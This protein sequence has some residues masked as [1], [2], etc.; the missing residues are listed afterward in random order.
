MY[1]LKAF[2]E[3]T[4]R[5]THPHAGDIQW[6]SRRAR[7]AWEAAAFYA[8]T[9]DGTRFSAGAFSDLHLSRLS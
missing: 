6:R 9:P 4:N 2:N 3:C 8:Q 1:G 5:C 7:S